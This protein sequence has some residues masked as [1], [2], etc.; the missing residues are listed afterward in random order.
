ME[1]YDVIV[2]GAGPAGYVAALRCQQLGMKVACVDK[3]LDPTGKPRL[4]GTCLNVG[5]IPSKAMLESSHH[6]EFISD[7]ADEHGIKVKEVVADIKK[8]LA[9]KTQIINELTGG[10]EILFDVKGIKW[11]QGTATLLTNSVVRVVS[12][13]AEETQV[14]AKHIILAPGSVPT[15]MTEAPFDGDLICDSEDALAWEK[16]PKRLGVLGAGVIALEMGSV[17][18]RLGSQVTLFHPSATFLRNAD[19]T[20]AK[21]VKKTFLKQGL[22]IL[23]GHK[24]VTVK[25]SAKTVQVTVMGADE[26][27][28]HYTFDKLLV[29]TGRTPYTKNIVDP[30]VGLSIDDKGRIEVDE[31]CRTNIPNVYAIGDCV[32]G[33]MLA[34]KGS[35]EGVVVAERISGQKPHLNYGAVPYVIYT[36]PEIAWVGYTEEQLKQKGIEYKTGSFAV[37][38]NGRAK[39][40]G[41]NAVGVCKFVADAKTDRVLGMHLF[42]PQASELISIGV[43]AIETESSSE[44]L[45][46][47]IFAHPTLSEIVHEAALDVDNRA[48][49]AIK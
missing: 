29:A 15:E 46:R 7:E 9:R 43:Q 31:D 3:W 35:E 28:K 33:D 26:K 21:N 48:L 25:K 2:I 12:H 14:S 38:A 23:S 19:Q 34:H 20:V 4:G 41:K 30:A 47:T 13:K 44:D 36:F 8:M 16:P 22:E 24:V 39:S 42:S 27:E 5:C 49:H 40:I 18:R 45:A 17:W 6:F 10:I 32:R 37:T 1:N 11:Y